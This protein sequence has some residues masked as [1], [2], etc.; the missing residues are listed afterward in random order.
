MQNILPN[1]FIHPSPPSKK[2]S[3]KIKVVEEPQP[4]NSKQNPLKH[5]NHFKILLLDVKSVLYLLF[6]WSNLI[7]Y[8]LKKFNQNIK[9][10]DTESTDQ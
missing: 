7:M 5:N 1:D 4:V 8:N 10:Q 2:K 6:R 9:M 3:N